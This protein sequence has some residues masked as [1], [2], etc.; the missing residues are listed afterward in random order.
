VDHSTGG[1]DPTAAASAGASGP[2]D[3]PPARAV[4]DPLPEGLPRDLERPGGLPP[5]PG[6]PDRPPASPEHVQTHLSHVLL[7]PERVYK[8]HKAVDLGFVDF[9]R[10]AERNADAA[11]EVRLNRRLAP[12]VYLGVAP[13][14]RD[15]AS[16]HLRVGALRADPSAL[17]DDCE[18]CVVMR[19]LPEGRDALSLLEAGALDRAELE[20]VADR[21]AGFHDAQG[22]G[23]PAPFAPGV[24]R[25]RVAAPVRANCDAIEG[26]GADAL[27]G[28]RV[29]ALRERSEAALERLAGPLEARRRQGLAVDGHGDL[30]LPHIWLERG[31]AP[32]VIIDCI[33]F[34][35]TLRRIDA[36]SDVAFLAMDLRYRGR[37]DLAEALLSRYAATRDDYG[38]YEVVDFY[39]SYRAA[40]RAKV[41]ALTSGEQEVPAAQRERARAS[42]S[43][44][45]ELALAA[46]EETAPGAVFLVGGVVGTG[47]STAAR[48]LAE[49]VG[50]VVLSSDRLRKRLAGLAPGAPGSDALYRPGA[51]QAVYDGLLERAER[52]A[53]S[54]RP[55]V[56][57]ATWSRRDLRERAR[58]LAARLGVPC[59]M[60]E[61]RCPRD[62]ALRRLAR[63]AERGGDPSDAGPERY[64]ASVAEFEPLAGWDASRHLALDT[65]ASDW[66]ERLR[67]F[68]GAA[69]AAPG[70]G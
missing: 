37:R 5:D 4:A 46:L 56:I 8:L 42:A 11:R 38:L 31:D 18:H 1:A 15:P 58:E 12:D 22:L 14:E 35:E 3:G 41:A 34:D 24:W 13:V 49:A 53:A 44:H 30:H 26:A 2:S 33:A 67:A 55:A 63:R 25:E 65:H 40:V 45:L 70:D 29:G 16:G 69:E 20:R 19:R 57:D 52:V 60:V 36:A 17:R 48:A 59:R 61:T 68:A 39:V 47:K 27:P 9:S 23:Q 21:V 54:G 6:S 32:P 64:D 66:R 62:E 50:A 43:R 7:T 28:D 51:R 10:R